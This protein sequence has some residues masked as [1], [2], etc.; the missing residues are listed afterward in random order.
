MLLRHVYINVFTQKFNICF[1]EM[2][3]ILLSFNIFGINCLVNTL[4]WQVEI[5]TI[6]RIKSQTQFNMEFSPF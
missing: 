3:N 2:K 1:G 5:D 6:N 4:I